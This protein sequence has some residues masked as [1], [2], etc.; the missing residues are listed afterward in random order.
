METAC[1]QACEWQRIQPS[2]APYISVNVSA[3]QAADAGMVSDVARIIADADLAP[4]LLQLELTE[5]VLVEE[6]SR[7]LEALQKLS[8]MGVRI[9][10]DDF[11][12]GY[13]NLAYLRRLPVDALKLSA[14]FIRELWPDGPTDE[15]VISALTGLAHTLGLS[16]TVEG[17]ETS[18]QADRLAALGCDMAQGWYFASA[19]PADHIT[20]LLHDTPRPRF[21]RPPH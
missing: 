5:S 3:Q 19:V 7:P 21:P 2:A 4:E 14:S 10:A 15:P 17:V 1:R 16:V 20:A 13:S 11:G 9:A 18:E 8:A 12:S 6:D